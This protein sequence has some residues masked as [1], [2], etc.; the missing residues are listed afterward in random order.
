MDLGDSA[1][2]QIKIPGLHFMAPR[3]R[4]SGA[5]RRRKTSWVSVCL[6]LYAPG[7]KLGCILDCISVLKWWTR[8]HSIPVRLR[9]VTQG[10]RGPESTIGWPLRVNLEGL[11]CYLSA[12]PAGSEEVV[13]SPRC[14]IRGGAAAPLIVLVVSCRAGYSAFW[15]VFQS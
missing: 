2:L 7:R 8:G 4:W 5:A 3:V 15:T 12:R 10:I 6:F 9:T 1:S 14:F 13:R 11:S